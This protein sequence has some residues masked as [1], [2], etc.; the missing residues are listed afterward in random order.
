ML[1]LLLFVLIWIFAGICNVAMLGKNTNIVIDKMNIDHT[2]FCI[3]GG[4]LL[5]LFI[6]YMVLYGRIVK[7]IRGGR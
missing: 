5:F 1:K 6:L 4:L 7:I 2:G 3:F